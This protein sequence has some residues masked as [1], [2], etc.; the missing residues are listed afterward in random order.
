MTSPHGRGNDHHTKCKFYAQWKYFFLLM[1]VFGLYYD[2]CMDNKGIERRKYLSERAI[3]HYSFCLTLLMFLNCIRFFAVSFDKSDAY[4]SSLFVKVCVVLWN[5]ESFVNTF[6]CYR[7]C[8]KKK[9]IHRYILHY[10]KLCEG[11]SDSE[12]YFQRVKKFTN[13]LLTMILILI[14]IFSVLFNSLFFKTNS[15][16]DIYAFPYVFNSKQLTIEDKI[17]KTVCSVFCVYQFAARLFSKAIV[18][19]VCEYVYFKVHFY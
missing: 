3:K 11:N 15:M 19:L 8:S 2:E 12:K 17:V 6:N 18:F 13:I 16:F 1:K 10:S 7:A 14:I 4:G 9:C 5:L